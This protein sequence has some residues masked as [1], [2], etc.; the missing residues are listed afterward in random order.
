M[1]ILFA[2][3]SSDTLPPNINK[4]T[5]LYR[6]FEKTEAGQP[7][8]ATA[9][10]MKRVNE[11]WKHVQARAAIGTCNDY[12]EGLT[13]KVTLRKVL[14]EGPITLWLLQPR[15]GFTMEKVP[16]GNS[17]GRDIGIKPS[18]LEPGNALE[19]VCTFIH[20][21]AHVAGASTN[22]DP[23][24]PH[25]LDAEKALKKC[26]CGSKYNKDNLGYHIRTQNPSKFQVV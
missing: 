11:A 5:Y 10:A 13:R 15:E 22:S 23:A 24:D 8:P 19:L 20:E 21:L 9:D 17:A 4:K 3:I 25:S 6:P 14:D 18:L 26:S 7:T 2:G 16:V 12:F 1:A